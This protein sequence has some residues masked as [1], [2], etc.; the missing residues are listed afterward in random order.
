MDTSQHKRYFEFSKEVNDLITSGQFLTINIYQDSNGNTPATDNNS[1]P[2]MGK[3]ITSIAY[4]FPSEDG[5]TNG[6]LLISFD[7]DSNFTANDGV[8]DY[9][10]SF[11]NTPTPIAQLI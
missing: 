1:N 8:S 11:T 5:T 10:F 7:D 2:I 6:F 3:N 9:W 4:H